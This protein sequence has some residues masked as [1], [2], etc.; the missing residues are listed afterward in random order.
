MPCK[1]LTLLPH[2]FCNF[3]HLIQNTQKIPAPEFGD[4]FFGITAPNEFE[5]LNRHNHYFSN[6]V[7]I[8]CIHHC[9]FTY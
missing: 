3:L 6:K 8:C 5:R 4:L 7:L 9:L 1:T 2:L